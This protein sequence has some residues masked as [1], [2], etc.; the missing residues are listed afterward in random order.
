M[1]RRTHSEARDASRRHDRKTRGQ[2]L[3]EFALVLPIMLL[4]L[5][6][7]VDF[8]RLFYTHISVSNAA[9]EGAFHAATHAGDSDYDEDAYTL[10]VA[11]AAS[12]QANAQTQGGE[13]AMSVTGPSCFSA[14]TSAAVRCDLAS[15]YATGIGNQVSVG[16]SQTFTFMTPLIGDLFGGSLPVSVTAT[17]P[18]LD[19]STISVYPED[20]ATPTPTPTPTATPT[21]TPTPSPTPAPTAPG[22]TP[23]PTPTPVPTPTPTPYCPVPNYFNTY[24]ADPDALDTWTSAGFTGTLTDTTGGKKIKS[25]TITAG[26]SVLCTS[27]MTV[28]DKN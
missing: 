12:T 16:V 15:G 22:A 8:G 1:Y 5:L 14:S 11:A 24:F 21:P 7:A 28:D 20:S 10:A 19:R 23:T 2:A 6:L 26:S 13:G 25:Q 3:V 27:S 18:V 17:A 4:I 9:R